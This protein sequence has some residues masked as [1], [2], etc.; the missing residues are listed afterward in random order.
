MC[1]RPVPRTDARLTATAIFDKGRC[2][3]ASALAAREESLKFQSCALVASGLHRSLG[4]SGWR[5]I[6]LFGQRYLSAGV[7][8]ALGPEDCLC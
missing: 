4:D 7:L 2:T 5:K 3:F 8:L 6:D 1:C